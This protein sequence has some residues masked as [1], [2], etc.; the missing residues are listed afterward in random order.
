MAERALALAPGNVQLIEQRAISELQAGD[1]P[2]AHR[3]LTGS[4]P[5][6]DQRALIAFTAEYSDLGWTLDSAQEATLL[7]MRPDMFDSDTATWAAVLAQQY[8]L[9]GDSLR[10]RAYADTAVKYFTAQVQLTPLDD[11]R[12]TFR[13]LTLAYLGR[14]DEA[15]AEGKRGVALRS[16][17]RDALYGPYA[18]HQMARIYILAGQQDHAIDLLEQLFKKPYYLTPAWLRIDPT[19]KPLRGN[20]RFEKLTEATKPVA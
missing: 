9:R 17:D 4:S 7:A 13:G 6:V 3:V 15:I 5:Q 18:I 1:L 10:M 11:Q 2:T 19:F 8:Y 14:F 20:P 16:V 12:H